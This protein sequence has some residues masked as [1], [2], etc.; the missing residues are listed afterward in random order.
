MTSCRLNLK[1]TQY[2][3]SD[4]GFKQV[5]GF[6]KFKIASMDSFANTSI[7]ILTIITGIIFL[8]IY[9]NCQTALA[10]KLIIDTVN[11]IVKTVTGS[12]IQWCHLHANSST[13]IP[14]GIGLHL[15]A[16]ARTLVDKNGLYETDRLLSTLL[17][18]L[19]STYTAYCA[20]FTARQIFHQ[21]KLPGN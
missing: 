11:S 5:K 14:D 10:H 18:C 2:L 4:I 19:M 16:L 1:K 12:D 13:E 15:Q 3:Q 8:C 20:M 21:E 9:L 6:H 7:L 17:Y